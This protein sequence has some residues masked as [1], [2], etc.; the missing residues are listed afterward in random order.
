MRAAVL[1][2]FL[3]TACLLGLTGLVAYWR[4]WIVAVDRAYREAED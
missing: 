1:W 4:E 2:A 3:L